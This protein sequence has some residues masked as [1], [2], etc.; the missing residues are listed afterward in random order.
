VALFYSRFHS[1]KRV[2]E[3]IDLWLERAPSQWLL[4]L[5]GIPEEYSAD[6]LERYVLKNSGQGRVRAFNG[7]GRPDPYAVASL[8]LLPS[9]NENFGLVVAEAMASGVPVLVTDTTPWRAIARREI[10]WCVPWAD[11][12]D[13]LAAATAE[14][15]D[16]R[17][18]RGDQARTWV[19]NEFS[20]DRS[21]RQLGEFYATL[22]PGP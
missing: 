8:L 3:L 16:Q 1:K 19:V 14:P 9:H 2:I 18:A 11:F 12:G 4:L 6:T 13:A 15:A 5:V 20:W 17:R 22:R 7:L 21:A 10:G